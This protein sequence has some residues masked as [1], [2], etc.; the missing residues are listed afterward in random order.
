MSSGKTG[1]STKLIKY[2]EIN[3]KENHYLGESMATYRK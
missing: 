1:I 2:N 3:G